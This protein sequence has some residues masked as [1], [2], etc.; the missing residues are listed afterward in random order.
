[1]P[2]VVEDGT[3][4]PNSN[5]YASVAFA[6]A[7]F[8]ERGNHKWCN[9]DI[10]KKQTLLIQGTDYI[11]LRWASQFRG[12]KA[13]EDQ[14]LAFPR[15]YTRFA[16]EPDDLPLAIQKAT[17]EYALRANDGP[18]APDL[19]TDE[20]GFAIQRRKEKVGPI[21]E[22]VEFATGQNGSMQRQTAWR[23]YPAVDYL[24]VPFLAATSGRVIRN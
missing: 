9:I 5:S 18:L 3:G 4:L 16:Y 21:E 8:A 14:A 2:F 10:D 11:E 20:S 12:C 1:M 19:L 13:V 7:Y 17:A 15:S 23:V 24:L 6:D 22:E